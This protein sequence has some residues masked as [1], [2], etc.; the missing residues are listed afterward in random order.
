MESHSNLRF[1]HP[2]APVTANRKA[3]ASGNV[4]AKRRR[5]LNKRKSEAKACIPKFLDEFLINLASAGILDTFC[6]FVT[7]VAKHLFPLD[8]IS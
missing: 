3:E 5:F 1:D 2:T 8:N 4:K 6:S 7:L